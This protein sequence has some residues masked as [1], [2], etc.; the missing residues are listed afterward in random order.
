MHS[1]P[2]LGALG[3]TF[4]VMRGMEFVALVTIVGLTSNFISEMVMADY[5]APSALIGTLVVS[6]I[7]TLYIAI[8]YILYW[9]FML[10]L[11]IAAGA[12]S[13][14]L[15]A[16]IV[17]ACTVGKPVSYLSC[18]KFPADGN[19]ANFINSL[20]HNVYHSRS[21]TFQWV[22]ADK[23]SCYQIKAIWGLSIALC[24]LFAFSAVTSLCLWKRTKVPS[25]PKDIE[26]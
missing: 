4:T 1:A 13:L 23:A 15:I 14:I 11:L 25:A 20:F 22:D 5:A 3:M 8:S 6:C 24:V 21:N 7:A 16:C 19:T 18:P 10:P 17:V 26:N 12:D 2:A 9:D